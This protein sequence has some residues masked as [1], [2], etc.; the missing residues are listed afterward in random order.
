MINKIITWN[1][2]HGGGSRVLDIINT[3]SKHADATTIVL[4]EFRNNDNAVLIRKALVDFGFI[5]QFTTNAPFNKNSILIVSKENLQSKTFPEL[6]NHSERVI[7]VY[8]NNFSIYGCYFPQAEEKKYVFEFLLNEIRNNPDENIIITG[9]INTGKHYI[10]E[11]G[12]TFFHSEYI[13]KIEEMGLFDAWRYI[14]KD[15]TEYSW[16]SSYGNGFRLDHFFLKNNLKDN[17]LNCEYIHKYRE[18]K[19]TDHSMMILELNDFIHS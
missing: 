4:T 2:R 8:N 7:K 10:D 1:I 6:N 14:H 16:Y 11:I 12:S 13:Q 15:K 9:D 3:L 17:V 5:N 19:I 18:Q